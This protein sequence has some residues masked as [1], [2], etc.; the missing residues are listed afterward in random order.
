[1]VAL[2]MLAWERKAVA[3]ADWPTHAEVLTFMHKTVERRYL[4]HL[5]KNLPDNAP[6]ELLGEM[7]TYQ[8]VYKQP[9][10]G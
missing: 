1:V 9:K 8:A 4:L 6:L 10:G 3:A 7:A 2:V 5:P